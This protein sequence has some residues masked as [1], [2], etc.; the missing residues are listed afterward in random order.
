MTEK[1]IVTVEWGMATYDF[2]ASTLDGAFKMML[3]HCGEDAMV[4]R[5]SQ[6]Y[7]D[8]NFDMVY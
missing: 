5:V 8:G 3:R 7:C 4:V 1:Y 2:V 6:Q